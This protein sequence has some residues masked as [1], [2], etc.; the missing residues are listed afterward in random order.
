MFSVPE[1]PL[2]T[3]QVDFTVAVSFGQSV[4]PHEHWDELVHW[5]YALPILETRH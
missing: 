2:R 1:P 5:R 4:S 3:H